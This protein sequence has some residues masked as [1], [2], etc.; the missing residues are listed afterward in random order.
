VATTHVLLL[1]GINVGGN[2]RIGMAPLRAALEEA[3]F[4]GVKTYLQSG[5]AVVTASSASPAKVGR[6]VERVIE[7]AFGLKIKVVVRSRRQI[8]QVIANDPFGA[9][10]ENPSRYF[11]TFLDPAPDPGKLAHLAAADFEPERFVLDGDTLY[12]WYPEGIRD[13]PLEKAIQKA[14]LGVTTTARNWNTVNKLLDLAEEQ[15]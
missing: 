8:E 4:T 3:G 1:R 7:D 13:S 2:N 15:R 12:L 9:V 6:E 10:A 11:V 5:N 14:K